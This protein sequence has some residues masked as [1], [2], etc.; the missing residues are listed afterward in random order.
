M[1]QQNP[2]SRHLSTLHSDKRDKNVSGTSCLCSVPC[3]SLIPLSLPTRHFFKTRKQ[4]LFSIPCRASKITLTTCIKNARQQVKH[5]FIL[6]AKCH[7][8]YPLSSAPQTTSLQ[9]ILCPSMR[10]KEDRTG[11]FQTRILI[12][13]CKIYFLNAT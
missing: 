10:A 6:K 11:K 1:G 2:I 8:P 7:I 3:T 9:C 5:F 12:R 4:K 13:M